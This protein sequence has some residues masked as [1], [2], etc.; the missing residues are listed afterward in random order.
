MKMA[1]PKEEW[2]HLALLIAILLLFIATPAVVAL[3][4][5]MLV[6]NILVAIVFVTGI[7]CSQ[8]AETVVCRGDRF[9][10]SHGDARLCSSLLPKTLG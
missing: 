8:P 3:P 6:M 2:R 5:G 9:V 10:R 7:V 4:R 1:A